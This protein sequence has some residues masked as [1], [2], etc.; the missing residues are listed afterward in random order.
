MSTLPPRN[1]VIYQSEA[2]FVSPDATGYHLYYHPPTP[3]DDPGDNSNFSKLFTGWNGGM[4]GPS[5]SACLVSGH[6]AGGKQIVLMPALE[7]GGLIRL[8][9]FTGTRMHGLT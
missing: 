1:R 3:A 7:L 4:T 2:L 8:M 9:H 5:F 6:G